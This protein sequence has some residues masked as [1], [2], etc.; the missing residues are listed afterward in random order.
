[1]SSRDA[2]RSLLKG[3]SSGDKYRQYSSLFRHFLFSDF[4]EELIS[5]SYMT[6]NTMFV[7]TYGSKYLVNADVFLKLYENLKAYYK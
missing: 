5:N 6:M 4:F 2:F 3:S 1:M 7:D